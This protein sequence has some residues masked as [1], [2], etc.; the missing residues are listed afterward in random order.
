MI[1]ENSISDQFRKLSAPSVAVAVIKGGDVD[2]IPFPLESEVIRGAVDRR[3]REFAAGRHCARAALQKL[4]GPVVSI[5]VDTARAPIW[6]AGFVGSI[7]HCSGFCC[8]AVA[9]QTDLVS[10]GID[11]E[12][13]KP[14]EAAL[15]AI[16]CREEELAA[17]GELSNLPDVDWP[18][19][20]FSAKE[21]FYKAC[22][23]I[24][25]LFLDFPD[26]R[27]DFLEYDLEG[28]AFTATLLV[29]ELAI[30]CPETAMLRGRWMVSAGFVFTAVVV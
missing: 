6:P 21:A 12:D 7:S 1:D 22:Y 13:S 27:I 26:V 28:G 8:A 25:Q 10:L 19:I 29:T 11:V 18:K 15:A 16:I 5:G 17:I 24:V 2:L 9:R 3:R 23:P 30:K 4:G 20:I 14:L